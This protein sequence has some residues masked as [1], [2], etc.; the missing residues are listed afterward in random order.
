MAG[1]RICVGAFAGAHGVRGQVR[2]TAFTAD[3]DDL[4]AYGPV[5]DETGGRRYEI[6]VVGRSRGQIIARVAGVG[7]RDAAE[8]LKGTR[9]YVDRATL[10]ATEADEFYHAD[11]I[12]LAVLDRDGAAIGTI[13]GVFDFGAGDVLEVAPAAGPTLMVRFTREAVPE[14]DLEGGKVVV[15]LPPEAPAGDG[16]E[17][18]GRTE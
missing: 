7:D 3:P 4:T 15:D 17:E 10:P 12:G 18:D 13:R 14:V 9:L 2:I 8:A 1:P 11:L 6:E 16:E 5:G